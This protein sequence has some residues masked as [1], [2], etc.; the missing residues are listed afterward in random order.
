[1]IA[2][3]IG[4]P[5]QSQSHC[6]GFAAAVTCVARRIRTQ[7]T[8]CFCEWRRGRPNARPAL[9]GDANDDKLF[10]ALLLGGT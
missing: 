6:S 7:R 1:M 4:A 9:F 5:K 3:R 2:P 8:A 10:V